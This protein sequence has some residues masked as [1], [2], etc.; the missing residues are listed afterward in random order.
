[1]NT[2]IWLNDMA[3]AL[4]EKLKT[5]DKILPSEFPD[6]IREITGGGGENAL[7]NAPSGWE[8]TAVPN[9][10]AV[11]KVYFNTALSVD[12]VVDI[13]ENSGIT[14]LYQEDL[15]LGYACLGNAEGSM[16]IMIANPSL[17]IAKQ[18]N[19]WA[20]VT[21]NTPDTTIFNSNSELE[22][23]FGFVGWKPDF[24]GEMEINLEVI[25]G[26][27][28]MPI[29]QE[30]NLISNLFSI[31]PFEQKFEELLLEG[32]YDGSTVEVDVQAAGD[33][34]GTPVPSGEGQTIEKVYLNTNLSTDKVV[35]I[36]KELFDRHP[37]F[38]DW[39]CCDG[40]GAIGAGRTDNG[41]GTTTYYIMNDIDGYTYF[42][43][44]STDFTN[45]VGWNPEFSG[46]VE[47]TPDLEIISANYDTYSSEVS[48]LF[49]ITPFTQ[50]EP[51]IDMKSYID[52]TQI[53]LKINL[54]NVATAAYVATPSGWEGTAVPNSGAVEK[55]YFNTALSVDE[56]VDI[57]ENS[58]ITMLYQ[59]D[60]LLGYAC[61]GN[62]EGS[63]MIMIANPSLL[64]AKQVNGWAL[65][66]GNTPDTTIFN[67]NSEL[68]DTFGFVGWKPDFTGEMEIN[69]EVISGFPEMPIGQENNLISNLFS[70][71]PFEQKFEEL[72]LEGKYDGS[73]VEV[74]VQAAG[75]WQ[76]TPVPSG[77]GQTI[78][79]VYL[80]TNLSTD[81]VVKIIKELFDRHPEFD[82]WYCCDGDGAIGAGRTDN[83]D[84]TTTYYIM[85]DIDGYTYFTSA[86][87]DFTNFVGW[88]PEFSGVVES[89]PD[90]EIISA[91]YDTYSSEVSSLFSI[92]PFTQSEP[93]ID[94]K[95][96]IDNTQIPLKI[97]LTN[98]PSGGEG[99]KI[100]A[101]AVGVEVPGDSTLTNIYVNT[102]L[103][104]AEVNA[105]LETIEFKNS[106]DYYTVYAFMKGSDAA[107][108]RVQKGYPGYIIQNPLTNV[109]IYDSTGGSGSS[110][111]G[112][113]P[114]FD[115]V[116]AYAKFVEDNSYG[117]AESLSDNQNDKLIDLFSAIPYEDEVVELSGN[118]D[119][120]SL[121]L[122]SQ[123]YGTVVVP[124]DSTL[125]NIY[126]N[127]GLGIAEVNAVLETIEFK[128]SSD[129][130]TVY[131]FMKGS[132]AAYL[133]VQKGYPGYIIQNPL[134][135]VK[136]YDSTGGSGS[137]FEGW[138][139]DFD[140]VIAYA[141]F[142]EDN[143]YGYAESLSDNQNDKL[144]DLFSAT[145]FG[146]NEIVI[147]LKE[148]LA[149]GKMPLSI[150]IKL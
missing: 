140:G 141:K 119:G 87:T 100:N 96:Y 22:D 31:T 34:Q 116:I 49:S 90:L 11:E 103:G 125:T 8:G 32:K 46:V 135:N 24:T 59:E 85:N 88:N 107:Y 42:T 13:I 5:T 43:S 111:E 44:A 61:L 65:V 3:K 15:L 113:N 16:M 19:G 1:M 104:I 53:P 82:D 55:V 69:L 136:I 93:C 143:S 29:G 81:K 25:S 39:Y 20:L 48:S 74:D 26:F 56:V 139:P 130:Y 63:M 33:W 6:K 114:D 101:P 126:V 38:D 138:N 80:N 147:N 105:V 36:I 91:N 137:S 52:N 57:I 145:P 14:M 71:T 67:S 41:D 86:S 40:D 50:S 35:K 148:L 146:A 45:F 12:E 64:I 54:T 72:L 108:L 9:S 60:L 28:E 7:I 78:E 95:S 66:T 84:G 89:T 75:D 92:T 77:E 23:T 106:S 121:E 110:F 70:I 129:Y 76:G 51:C 37:E 120:S 4:Q 18:V 128:N 127:T 68:E 79:K 122:D 123:N 115:G 112:W 94:M 10:G 150:K 21:G 73:T 27:P 132:D 30:N 118:Y 47:S 131:A 17:L 149:E 62:A 134:T 102:G 98:M 109:K 97:N 144:I 133:R 2:K 117:Y 83:G 124:G 99:V 142:V 58:G